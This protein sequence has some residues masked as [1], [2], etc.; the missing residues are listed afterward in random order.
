MP[1]WFRL[2]PP[3]RPMKADW[4]VEVG[5]RKPF[6]LMVGTVEPRKNVLLAAKVV[7][8][9][10]ERGRDLR[11]VLVGRRGWLGD[12]D[13][14]ALK[15]CESQGTVVWPGYVTDEQRDA[16]YAQASALLMPSVYEGFGMPLVEAMAAGVPCC[17]SAIPVFEEVAGDAALRLDPAQPEAWVDAIEQLL[18]DPTL[19]DSLRAA[20]RTV[21]ATYSLQRT[22]AA[23]ARAVAQL[24]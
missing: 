18:D 11:L 2:N 10:R 4:L 9:L 21:A 5:V 19:A 22:A 20:G 23:F 1:P 13:L 6:V 16:L 7:A 3:D 14:A 17:C 12:R 24:D 15:E 8:R